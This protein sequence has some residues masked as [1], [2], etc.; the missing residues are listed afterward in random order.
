METSTNDGRKAGGQAP[1]HPRRAKGTVA[2]R[3]EGFAI[4]PV[5]GADPLFASGRHEGARFVVSDEEG[6]EGRGL[7]SWFVL[8]GTGGLEPPT[9]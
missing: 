5:T 4:Q 3:P 7:R 8:V 2:A 6:R 9:P 1:T